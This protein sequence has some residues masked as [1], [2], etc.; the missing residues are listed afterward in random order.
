MG[1]AEELK[2]YAVGGRRVVY[3][4]PEGA[5][6]LRTHLRSR[7]FPA[8]LTR[9]AGPGLDWLELERHSDLR[10]AQAAVDDWPLIR[11]LQGATMQQAKTLQH[12]QA[13]LQTLLA[14]AE[15]RDHL[16]ELASSYTAAGGRVRPWGTSVVTYILVHERQQGLIVG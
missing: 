9:T 8:G 2:V 11:D 1:S 12:R 4:R 6:E 3:V 10:D 16:E 14:T 7:G 13:E 15:G 5:D